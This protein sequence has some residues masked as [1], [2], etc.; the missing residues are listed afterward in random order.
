MSILDDISQAFDPSPLP[1]G[2]AVYVDCRAVRGGSDILVELG[3]KVQRSDRTCQLY[4]GHRGGGKSTELLRLQAEL[5]RKG[6]FVVYFAAEDGDINPEDVEYT[7]I[8]LACTRHLLE[9]L[10]SVDPEPVSNWLRD[11]WQALNE[12]L[13]TEINVSDLKT[14]VLIQQIAKITANIRAQPS[15]RY[16][17]CQLLNPHTETLVVALN[18]FIA[19]AKRK[20]PQGKTKLV[21]IA[22]G[23]DKITPIVQDGGRTNHDEIF[24]DRAEQ[25][26]A[27]D[28]HVIYT[29]PISLVLSNRASDLMEI[30]NCVPHVLPMVMVQTRTNEAHS[31]GVAALKEIVRSRIQS[32]ASAKKLSLET[33]IFDNPGTLNHLCLITGGHVRNLILL[34]Q[35]A[36]DYNDDNLP[37]RATAVQQGIRQLRTTYRTTVNSDQWILLAKVFRTKRIE[38]DTTHRSLLFTRCLLEYCEDDGDGERW[39]DV[40]PMLRD[41]PEFKD[42]LAAYDRSTAHHEP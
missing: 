29:V 19:A 3:K 1:A 42:A 17:I 25:L 8:L 41:V 32:I 21:V 36:I 9:S 4:S 26:K 33:A 34:M 23:L 13:Q 15:Q 31:L 7:D 40:H 37:L 2:S 22:D 27:L 5:D 20:L 39:H 16:Q 11:R 30:Y 38:H 24:I 18:Q 12:V 28:C 35:L 6:C 14:E 10:K